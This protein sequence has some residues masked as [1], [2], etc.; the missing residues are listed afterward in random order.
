MTGNLKQAEGKLTG[1]KTRENQ[2]KAEELLGKAKEKVTETVEKAK[3]LLT[4]D[5][6]EHKKITKYHLL[7]H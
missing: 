1:D 3:D 6:E 5:D 4:P 2:G 7:A